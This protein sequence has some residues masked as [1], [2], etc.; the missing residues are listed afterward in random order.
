M[1]AIAGL[2]RFSRVS[3]DAREA[4]VAAPIIGL[5]DGDVQALFGFVRR[6]GLSDAQA[7]DAVQEVHARL[8]VEY[9]RGIVIANP[10]AWAYRSIYRLAMD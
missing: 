4:G 5:A 10:R 1:N 6:L 9:R 7:D 3:G 8:L 2:V